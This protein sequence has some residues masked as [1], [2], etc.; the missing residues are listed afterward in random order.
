MGEENEGMH[1]PACERGARP[2]RTALASRLVRRRTFLAV[3]GAAAGYLLLARGGGRALAQREPPLTGLLVTLAATGETTRPGSG[4]AIQI[5][6]ANATGSA[7]A[8]VEVRAPLPS[9]TV[10]A[11]VGEGGAADGA[12]VGWT[13][14][15]L[16]AGGAARLTYRIVP[17]PG[18]DG[19]TLFRE[20]SL[21]PTVT[22]P[23]PAAAPV[24][25]PRL[26]LNGLWG[27]SEFRRTVL[28]TGLTILTRERP[29]TPTVA[30]QV[31]VRAGARDETDITHG[32]S[33]WL[34]HAFFLGTERRSGNEA[35]FN[36][37]SFVGGQFNA[38][39]SFEYTNYYN[40]VPAD[41]LDL[42]ID[43]LSDQILNSTFPRDTFDRER[44]VVLQEIR[45]A[46]SDPASTASREFYSLVFRDSPLRRDVLNVNG[47]V[48][49]I[50]IDVI[51]AYR[52]ERYTTGNTTVSAIGRLDH[53]ETVRKIA[54]AFAPLKRGPRADRPF[55][56][57]PPQTEPRRLERG[58]GTRTAE[59]RLGW[60]APGDESNEYATVEVID[61][62]LGTAG[63]RL[64]EEIRD[65]LSLV[66]SIAPAYF[67]GFDAGT[68]FI[69]ATTTPDRV[70]AAVAAILE[71]I[72][73]LRDGDVSEADVQ[74]G[75]RAI[76][77][78]RALSDEPN[79]GQSNVAIGEV[80]YTLESYEEFLARL[81]TVTPA[82]VQR[83]ARK[84]FDPTNYTLV[85]VRA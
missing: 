75:I 17:A 33:H 38:S 45:R 47:S 64:Q 53:D 61:E 7:L 4:L 51:L 69:A 8:G 55:T 36:A 37:I 67:N 59:I 25:L 76:A 21:Q 41:R 26:R 20:Q 85:V 12:A 81:S 9:G 6:L 52:D 83:V 30:V 56:V 63:R 22:L 29:E 80:A 48:A 58:E 10:A 5:D 68:F 62:I 44:Q 84:Y 39:T 77:G 79:F 73:R 74:A 78:R 42:A 2:A 11:E 82:E 54:Q 43:V 27:E 66:A 34:E 46:Q 35:V 3:S 40:V 16:A 13:G 57:E 24:I 15:S 23:A 1:S 71:Q 60:P 70:D 28:P 65:R 19:A 72:R 49:N 32:G 50:P 18:R 31:A 14:L